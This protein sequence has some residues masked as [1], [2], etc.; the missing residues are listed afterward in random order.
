MWRRVSLLFPLVLLL[1]VPATAKDKN[2]KKDQMPEFILRA[3][4]VRVVIDPNVGEPLYQ[5][6]A[7][8]M[9]RENVEKA[10]T[11]WGR[12][13]V[14]VLDGED[15]DLIIA[16]HTG[17]DR[18]VRPTIAGG[19]IDQRTGTTQSS[20]GSIRI[21]GQ[22]GQAPTND[23]T[24]DPQYPQNQGP[25]IGSEAGPRVDSFVVYQGHT[26]DPTYSP[27]GWRYTAKGCL[28]APQVRAVEEFRKA[29]AE[30]EKPTIPKQP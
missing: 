25:R 29:I 24:M 18:M 11:E 5:P 19:P 1:I 7:N 30:A 4:S 23:P 22:R 17:D 14:T 10:L 13:R 3:Q 2:K 27:A 12:Y 28:D 21:G 8:A 26:A 6:N 20:P 16:I 15:T 9:A